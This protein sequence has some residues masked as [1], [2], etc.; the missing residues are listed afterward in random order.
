MF[1]NTLFRGLLNTVTKITVN[2]V[3][4]F[5]FKIR[6]FLKCFDSNLNIFGRDCVPFF[7]LPLCLINL[8]YHTDISDICSHKIRVPANPMWSQLRNML[9]PGV[10]GTL[11]ACM[12]VNMYATYVFW[13]FREHMHIGMRIWVVRVLQKNIKS[14]LKCL[15]VI[16]FDAYCQGNC[17]AFS[18]CL[19]LGHAGS[20]HQCAL[21]WD[22]RVV[23]HALP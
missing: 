11:D 3:W 21:L 4:N 14:I 6:T 22:F 10:N 13:E 15:E 12:C 16:G 5:T 19:P 17:P 7:A 9:I 1:W 23:N 18:L 20:Q 8:K 2:V